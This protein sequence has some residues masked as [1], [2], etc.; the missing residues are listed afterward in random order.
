MVNS[1]VTIIFNSVPQDGDVLNILESNLGLNLNELF[2][3][4]RSG[5]GKVAIPILEADGITYKGYVSTNYKTAFNLD[6]NYS[7]LFTVVSTFGPAGSGIGTVMITANYPN[8]VFSTLENIGDIDVV[9]DNQTSAPDFDINSVAFSQGSSPNTH[10]RVTVSTSE[11]ATEVLSPLSISNN[12]YNPYFY[13]WIRGATILV[14]VKNANGNYASRTVELPKLL[15]ASNFNVRSLN[16]PNGATTTVTNVNSEGLVLQYSLDNVTWQTSNIFSGLAAGNFTLYVKDQ[17]GCT[18]SKTF[19]V[20]EFNINN[21]YFEIS[22]SNSIRYAKRITFGVSSNYRNDENTMSCEAQVQCPHPELQRFQS[23][24][25]ITTQF[26]SNYA[27]NDAVVIRENGNEVAIPVIKRSSNIGLKEKRDARKYDL[28]D[29]KTGIYF[30]SGSIYD[31]DTNAVVSSYSLN[32]SLPFWAQSKKYIVVNSDWFQIEEIVFDESKNAEVIVIED[33]YSGQ[34]TNVIAGSIYNLFDYEIYEYTVN[35]G[36]FIN[37]NIRVRLNNTDNNFVSIVH[38]SEL[39]NVK[40]K[41]E[42]TIEIKY[43]NTDNT[44]IFYGTGIEHKIR[45]MYQKI[46]GY[47]EDPSENYKTDTNTVLISADV[48]EGDEF[49]LEP[50]TKEMMRKIVR[51]LSHKIVYIDEIGY[52]KDGSI[53][54]EGPIDQSNL[55]IIKAK[56]TKNGNVYNTNSASGNDDEIYDGESY[57]VVG[58]VNSGSGFMRL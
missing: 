26:K 10:I 36:D 29:G 4:V 57:E 45:Q 43:K 25:N 1:S 40:E 51:A 54:V 7:G 20:S 24:D 18:V 30:I 58:F 33:N 21:P 15:N 22:K 44:D 3:A 17:Y 39:I 31:Y 47:K 49:L 50:V 9:I 35:M 53:E 2:K 37:E 56:M 12:S 13:D 6:Y 23:A 38:L 19:N 14:S 42:K 28:G 16:T 34:E 32:G 41:Q 8:A 52:T 5:S 48:Y 11:L 55:Y 27:N 46:S